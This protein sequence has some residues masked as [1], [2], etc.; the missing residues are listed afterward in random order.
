MSRYYF[1][2]REDF[3]KIRNAI[4]ETSIAYSSYM[5]R[6]YGEPK[7]TE[8]VLYVRNSDDDIVKGILVDR[9]VTKRPI[10]NEHGGLFGERD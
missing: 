7:P 2:A 4:E 3:I 6:P 10:V 8:Y 1:Y 5:H 9:G